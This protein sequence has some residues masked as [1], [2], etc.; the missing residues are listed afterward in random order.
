ME[1][2]NKKCEMHDFSFKLSGKEMQFRYRL[3]STH[4]Q[5]T[6]DSTERK[7]CVCVC[8]CVYVVCVCVLCVCVCACACV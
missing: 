7:V 3:D 4:E 1:A 2:E 6:L 8:V 5:W